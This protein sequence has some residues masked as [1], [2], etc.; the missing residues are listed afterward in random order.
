MPYKPG[1]PLIDR[2]LP[3]RIAAAMTFYTVWP[4][5]QLVNLMLHATGY[6][7]RRKL[8]GFSRA[9]LVS[10]HTTFLDPVLVSGVTL[11]RRTWQT[12]LEATVET[13]FLGTL[14]RLL[15]GVP[16]PRGRQGLKQLLDCCETAFRYRR[17]IHFYPEGECYLYNQRI[18]PFKPGAFF[19]AAELGIPVIPLVTVFSPGPR[20]PYSLWGRSR[21]R[22]KLVVLDAVYPDA[23][24]CRDG[25]GT[26]TA[27]SIREFAEDVRR[28]MQREIDARQGSSAFFRG[29]MKR[30]RGINDEGD[31]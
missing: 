30:I 5:G 21:P 10:N 3:F 8:T 15:G 28:I 7:N 13:P 6:E 14:T 31:R 27:A 22:E 9:V 23:Y 18:A 26:V 1:R 29:R 4:I 20:K 17:F 16:L 11:P 19:I 2:S 12:L 24:I 25:E